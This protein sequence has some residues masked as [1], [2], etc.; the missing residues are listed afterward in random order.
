MID[1]GDTVVPRDVQLSRDRVRLA[2]LQNEQIDNPDDTGLKQATADTTSRIATG[3]PFAAGTPFRNRGS[4]IASELRAKKETWTPVFQEA[5]PQAE[6]WTPVY[7]GRPEE[8]KPVEEPKTGVGKAAASGL[9]HGVLGLAEAVNTGLQFIGNR[10]GS[11]GMA[12]QGESGAQ[13]WNEKAKPYEPPAD[14]QGAI[15]DKP[16][17]LLKGTWWAYNLAEMAPSFAAAIIPGVGAAKAISVGGKAIGLTE[18]VIERLAIAGGA[19]VGG[20]AGGSLEGAQTYQEVLKRGAPEPEAAVAGSMMALASAALNAISVGKMILP[21]KANALRRFL[22]TG[23]VEGLTEWAEEPTEGAILS[24]TSV[25]KPEDDPMLRARQGLNVLPIAA[26]MGGGA[27]VMIGGPQTAQTPPGAAQPPAPAQPPPPPAGPPLAL[28][29]Q[30]GEPLVVFKDGSAMTR[31]QYEQEKANGMVHGEPVTPGGEPPAGGPPGGGTPEDRL[32]ALKQRVKDATGGAGIPAGS[33]LARQLQPLFDEMNQIE[34]EIAA[35]PEPLSPIDQARADAQ[36][37]KSGQDLPDADETR[38]KN[39]TLLSVYGENA[40]VR[41]VIESGQ[42]SAIGDAMLMAA[43]TVERVRGTL[44]QGPAQRDITPDILGAVDELAKIRDSGQTVAQVMAEGV[45]HDISYEGQQLIQFLDENANNSRKIA[46]FLEAYLHEVETATGVPSQVRGR[47]FDIIEE[48]RAAKQKAQEKAAVEEKKKTEERTKRQEEAKARVQKQDQTVETALLMAKAAGSGIQLSHLTAIE[49]AFQRAKEKQNAKSAKGSAAVQ[50]KPSGGPKGGAGQAQAGNIPRAVSKPA[51]ARDE[52]DSRPANEKSDRSGAAEGPVNRGAVIASELK[53]AAAPVVETAVASSPVESAPVAAAPKKNR[54]E[55]IAAEL[56]SKPVAESAPV[57]EGLQPRDRSRLAS[58]EQMRQIARNPDYLRLGPSR[59]PESGAPMVFSVGNIDPAGV[60]GREDVAV[61]ADGQRVKFRYAVVE[62]KNVQPS[63]FGDGSVNPAYESKMPGMVK[64]LNNGRAAGLRAAFQAGTAAEYVKALKADAEAHGIASMAGIKQPMLVRLYSENDNAGDMG[65]KSQGATLGMSVT[66]Q[67]VSDA[68]MLDDDMLALYQPVDVVSA[69]NRDFVRAFIGKLPEAARSGVMDADGMLSQDG[70][71][72]I[73]AAL[74]QSAY[75][76]STLVQELFESSDTDIK[77]IGTALKQIAGRWAM[78]RRNAEAGAIGGEFDTTENLVGALNIVRKARSEGRPVAEFAGQGDL[79]SGQFIA[80]LT[81][82]YLRVFYRGENYN[83][84]RSGEKVVTALSEYI[85]A[86]MATQ[87]ADMFGGDIVT[88]GR[89]L[90][91]ILEK[92]QKNEQPSTQARLIAEPGRPYGG[93]AAEPRQGGPGSVGETGRGEV[94]PT[95][96]E[97][98]LTSPTAAGLRAQAEAEE[99]AAKQKA[100]D[101]AAAEKARVGKPLKAD[102][103][104]LFFNQGSLF[105][106]VPGYTVGHEVR[107]DTGRAETGGTQAAQGELDLYA[108]TEIPGSPVQALEKIVVEP[109]QVGKRK[110]AFNRIRSA[111]EAAS[112]FQDLNRSPREKFQVLGLDKNNKPIAFFDLFAGTVTQ[113]SVYPREAWTAIYQTPGIKSVWIAHQHPSGVAEPSAADIRITQDLQKALTPDIGVT[114]N[115]HL[116]ITKNKTIDIGPRGDDY[117]SVNVAQGEPRYTLPIM[118]RAVVKQDQDDLAS[119]GSP[120]AVREFFRQ[121]DPKETGLLV[122]DAQHRATGWWPMSV[123]EMSTLRTGDVNTGMAALMRK[124][125]RGNAAAVIAY[126]PTSERAMISQETRGMET[127]EGAVRNVGTALRLADVKMLD[128]IVKEQNGGMTSF[129]E[130]GLSTGEQQGVFFSRNATTGERDLIVRHN[131]TEANLLHAVKMGGIPVPALAINRVGQ[132]FENFGEI[133]LIGD[134]AM[135]DPQGYARTKVFGADAYSPRYPTIHYKFVP[136]DSLRAELAPG[137]EATGSNIQWDEAHT[138]GAAQFENEPAIMWQFLRDK[139]I[140]PDI[141]MEKGVTP[142]RV[143]ELKA[144][145]FEP[146]FPAKPGDYVDHQELMRDEKFQRLANTLYSKEMRK[147][148]AGDLVTPFSKM[149]SGQRMNV[150]RSLAYEM[151][152]VGAPAKIDGPATRD[153]LRRQIRDKYDADFHAFANAQFAKLK[154][155]EHIFQG[156]TYAGNKKY[157][158]HTLDKVV[159]I[160]K[161]ELRGGERFN[162]GVGSLRAKFTPQFRS[163]TQIREAK[164]NLLGKEEFDAVKKEVDEDLKVIWDDLA[165]YSDRGREFGFG[166]TVIAVL[167]E[168]AKFGIPKALAEYGMKNVA[169]STKQKMAEFLTRLRN[170]PTEYFEAK[171]TRAVDIAEFRGA[172]VPEGTSQ[173]TIDI[174]KERGLDVETYKKNDPADRQ[175]A[176]KAITD[177]NPETR[178]AIGADQGPYHTPETLRT[179]LAEALNARS[180]GLGDAILAM[181][182]VDVIWLENAHW[183]EK[184]MGTRAFVTP[185]GHVTFIADMI[186]TAWTPEQLVGLAT[187]EIA[188]HAVKMNKGD[189]EWQ[190]IIKSVKTLRAIGR[191]DVKAAYAQAERAGTSAKL[192]D[193]EALGYLMQSSPNLPI[194]KRFIAW[195]RKMI[196]SLA[197]Q[198]PAAKGL[199]IV[200]WADSLTV[201]DLHAMAADAL[202][203]APGIGQQ[204]GEGTRLAT[205]FHGTPH[206]L[207]QE[208]GFPHGRFRLDRVGTGQG[209]ASYGHGI[210][211]GEAEGTGDSYRAELANDQPSTRIFANGIPLIDVFGGNNIRASDVGATLER[212]GLNLDK[213]IANADTDQVRYALEGLRKSEYF[214]KPAVITRQKPGS[215]YR[216]DIPDDVLPKLLDWDRPLRDQSATVQNAIGRFESRLMAHLNRI[217]HMEAELFRVGRLTGAQ[218]YQRLSQMLARAAEVEKRTA[219]DRRYEPDRRDDQS[220]SEYLASIGIPG[221]RYLDQGSRTPNVADEQLRKLF[222]KHGDVAKAVDEFMSHI[223]QSPKE[224]AKMRADL[225]AKFPHETYNYVIWDQKVL[226]RVAL[227]ERNGEKLDAMRE[228][229]RFSKQDQTQT[230]V[231]RSFETRRNEQLRTEGTEFVSQYRGHQIEKYTKDNGLTGAKTFWADVFRPDGTLATTLNATTQHQLAARVQKFIDSQPTN[232]DIRRSVGESASAA[233]D[234]A[235]GTFAEKLDVAKQAGYKAVATSFVNRIDQAMNP[236]GTLPEQEK[237]L[238]Q[239]GLAQ[240]LIEKAD[241]SAQGIRDA[242]PKATEA[243]KKAI[244]DYLTTAGATSANITPAMRPAAE[245][246]KAQIGKIGDELVAHGMLSTESREKYKDAYLPRLY[247]KHLLSEQDFRALGS[248]KKP[249]DM[250]YLKARKDISAEVRAVILGEVTDPGFLAAVAIAKPA[251]DMALLDWLAQISQNKNW[252]LPGTIIEYTSPLTGRTTKSTP[253]WLKEEAVQLRKQARYYTAEN[254]TKALAEAQA[255]DTVADEALEG[256]QGEHRDFKQIPN[257]ARYGMLRGMFVR[258]EIYNDLMGVNDFLPTDPGWFQNV[259]G[260]GGI[261]TKVTQIWKGMKVTM[262]PPAQVR[263]FVS[264]AIA[265]Q[266]FAGVPLRLVPA[267]IF[268]AISEIRTGGK[269]FLV[270]KEYGVGVST[271]ATQEVFRMKTELLDLEMKTRGL[272][273]LGRIHRIAALIM[274]KSSDFY[275]L[276]ETIFKTAVIIDGMDRQ[277]LTKEASVALAQKALF[278]YSLVHKSVRYARSAPIGV[279]FLTYS[280]KVLPRLIE[281]AM[282]HPQR[283]IPWVALFYGFPMIVASM[284]GVD[285]DDLDK[286]KMAMPEWLRDKGHAMI[287]PYKDDQGRWQI[288]DLGYFMPWTSWT[289]LAGNVAS[290]QPGKAVQTAGIFSGPITDIIVAIKTGKDPFTGRDIWNKGDPAERQLVSMMNYVWNMA[291]PPFITDRGLLSPMGLLDQ[292]HGGKAIQAITGTTNKYGEPRSTEI[293][294]MLYLA[295]INVQAITPE[296]TRAQNLKNM[297]RE[298]IDTKTMLMQKLQDRALDPEQRKELVKEYAGEIVQRTAKLQKYLRDSQI[299]PMLSTH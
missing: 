145:G 111:G 74:M 171:I 195:V 206:V 21:S 31:A 245:T 48:R 268:Q 117:N 191:A 83:R 201:D 71:R 180:K 99:A 116:I 244:F 85:D 33:M 50:G 34:A 37:L 101:E 77:A 142:E 97:A 41:H 115:G 27:G 22:T 127:F 47:A 150:A 265:M 241:E 18:K 149:D 184:A 179:D 93:R 20:T 51:Q 256:I 7:L 10:V 200:R 107:Q 214:T 8:A 1:L 95:E 252:I 4:Q 253:F 236:L 275:Q 239:R 78:L 203:A 248:G 75:G 185:D 63:H 190:G 76:D 121:F 132:P 135:A 259:F 156:F 282:L 53:V 25:A 9:T 24:Q 210:Y 254:A 288:V 202:R 188:V 246:I 70:R 280:I 64:A 28:G 6:T 45:S 36:I 68:K 86:A 267:R 175:R 231:D 273:A 2:L 134:K 16:E 162:Y 154:A 189:V 90:G 178:F 223:Y 226:D 290:G 207:A 299:A 82:A 133:T 42:F 169:D 158:A 266:L 114:L 232:P 233:F 38:M 198:L 11:K 295:G 204:T 15:F 87:G 46:D 229:A 66:E 30:A 56:K 129:A 26:V 159:S 124:V 44:A 19:I 119:L 209:A 258:T 272:G 155:T 255:M 289:Q 193:E 235:K 60:M 120:S 297:Q 219:E 62:A 263:N 234:K 212:N 105:Q 89:V 112:V 59:A 13:Y 52:G 194:V 35:R 225:I 153:A 92:E 183:A 269:H 143:A 230:P 152:K 123:A 293:Q 173:K 96:P 54:G 126:S 140:E 279:P 79:M 218:I 242:F 291:A 243:D 49:L 192:M 208:P 100:K 91:A 286:L 144:A 84:A 65:A 177:R 113:T 103:N 168:S 238:A 157:A 217:D 43:P 146:Y 14:I 136:K 23:A 40:A 222:A 161:K 216:L 257:T 296:F 138:R 131:L 151:Q 148:G 164:G 224:A 94:A 196:R 125:G 174:L 108:P 298:L 287:L 270:A 61:M 118:E 128:A 102:Q 281:T 88:P 109:E 80:Q 197:K 130:R 261:G 228:E 181:P 122:M 81:E 98:A 274:N 167:E 160:L 240:G 55:A 283:F 292:A 57:S 227:L 221:N 67:A 205:A 110:I 199:A 249:S 264:N 182:N 278:D 69:G 165:P 12:E 247:L 139:G 251:R 237:Y 215:L 186:P 260:Y 3:E 220:A 276:S 284:L 211:F 29:Y 285:K 170:M 104:D 73:E 271:F 72:R 106:S 262:N 250:G 32:A 58:T 137:V 17:L 39:A 294:A 166:D 147:A 141:V 176:V 213:A 5:A 187:H 163:V 172:A 277:G